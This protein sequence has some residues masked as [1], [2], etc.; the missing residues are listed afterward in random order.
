MWN[1]LCIMKGI[2]MC[3]EALIKALAERRYV[4]TYYSDSFFQ[5]SDASGVPC[6]LSGRRSR[7]L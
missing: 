1:I 5:R 6:V 3:P 4:Q 2:E 7:K